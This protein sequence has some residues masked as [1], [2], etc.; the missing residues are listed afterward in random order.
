MTSGTQILRI[1]LG[2]RWLLVAPAVIVL[3]WG[4]NHFL[5]L[6]QLY[7]EVDGFDQVEV[8]LILATYVLGIVPGFAL[9][10]AWSDRHGRKPILLAG[11]VLGMIGSAVLAFSSASFIGLCIGRLVSGLSV[12]AGMVVGTSWIKE[13]S[14]VDGRAEAGARRASSVMTL[15]FGGGAAVAGALAQWGPAPTT[16]PYEVHIGAC[17]VAL[18][19]L[20]RAPETR[21]FDANVTSLWG[22]LRVPKPARRQFFG[23]V[24]PIAPWVFAAPALAFAVGPSL[25]SGATEGIQIGFATLVTILTLGVG[26][27][28]QLFSRRLLVLLGRRAGLVGAALTATGAVLLVPAST[29]HSLLAV[30]LAAPIF[31]AGYGL[32]M[33]AGLTMVQGMATE[34]DLAGLTAVFYSLTYTGFLLPAI[35]TAVVGLWPMGVWLLITAALC[36]ACAGIAALATRTQS[37]PAL[38]NTRFSEEGIRE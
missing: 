1:R 13:L 3:G 23:L 24:L 20:L 4:G 6:M 16:L 36:L 11:L 17:V 22:D 32:T 27:V 10:G 33:V 21:A 2:R 29:Q 15:G 26:W 30:L 12:A 9:C 5:P 28:T 8:D 7:R 35:L 19:L 38:S 34:D 31:G 14:A 25:V 18:I 37:K